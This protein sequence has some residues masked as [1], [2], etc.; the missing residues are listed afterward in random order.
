VEPLREI[1]ILDRIGGGDAF[2]GGLLYGI[3]RGWPPEDW[4]KFGWATGAL[5]TASV[6]DY[7]TPADEEQVWSIYKGNAR[8]K[9]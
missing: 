9:R 3:L 6:Q 4:L 1:Q 8:V 7:A 5:A 2:V